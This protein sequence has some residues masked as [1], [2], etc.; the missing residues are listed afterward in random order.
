MKRCWPLRF[1]G[2]AIG[3]ATL[4]GVCLIGAWMPAKLGYCLNIT[5]SEPVG[6]YRQIGG[7]V[8]R[9]AL[10][11]LNRPHGSAAS[12]LGRYLPA[13][14]PLIKRIAAIPGDLVE[15]STEGVRVNGI[16]W[17]DS[18]PLTHDLEGRSLRPYPFGIS[19][20][21]A[22]QIWV[23]SNHPRGLDSRYF[24]PVTES[25]VISRLVP[26]VTWSN[27][28]TAAALD[29]TYAL[30]VAAI[31]LVLPATTVKATY[32][33]VVQPREVQPREVQEKVR[34]FS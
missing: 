8:E 27:R 21:P 34:R 10:V 31:A 6:I 13:N 23:M 15:V 29:L 4:V 20:V 30:C 14:I 24:G 28:E 11:L 22:G 16:L 25:S 1:A 26:I 5:P 2:A 3:S 9:G 17:P 33:L 7:G 32:A 18:V 12:I 19:R